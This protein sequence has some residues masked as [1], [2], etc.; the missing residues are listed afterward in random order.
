M[1]IVKDSKIVRLS[2]E[3]GSVRGTLRRAM[4][5]AREEGWKNVI[6]IGE[7]KENGAFYYSNSTYMERICLLEKTRHRMTAQQID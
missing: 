7:S 3:S 2:K 4:D 1:K 5:K 6:V